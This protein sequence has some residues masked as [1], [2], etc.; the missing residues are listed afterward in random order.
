MKPPFL[1]INGKA[2]N[3]P[4]FLSNGNKNFLLD[5][6]HFSYQPIDWIVSEVEG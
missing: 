6:N 1:R 3:R 5:Q 2:N 4:F